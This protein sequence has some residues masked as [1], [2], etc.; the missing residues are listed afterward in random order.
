MAEREVE[1]DRIDGIDGA[2]RRGNLRGHLPAGREA[3]R[4]PQAAAD[5]DNVRIEGHDELRP[6]HARPHARIDGV[7]AH[8]PS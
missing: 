5:P 2:E 6:R 4:E 7:A 1:A 3:P 8:H